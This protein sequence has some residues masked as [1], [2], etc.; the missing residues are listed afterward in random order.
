MARK[1]KQLS[2]D[3]KNLVI[4][5]RQD[6][7]TL[8]KIADTL[9]IPKGTVSDICVRYRDRGS[10]ENIPRKGR[11]PKLNERDSRSLIRLVHSNRKTPLGE[12]TAKFN[13]HRPEVVSKRTVQRCL[14]SHGYHR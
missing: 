7:N 3:V 13:E 11:T 6:G 8:Q 9:S 2:S 12:I 1:R 5:M 4:A 14:F 10:V